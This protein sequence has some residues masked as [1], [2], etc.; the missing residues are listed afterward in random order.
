MSKSPRTEVVTTTGETLTHPV[1]STT[2]LT[3]TH[4]VI[5]TTIFTLLVSVCLLLAIHI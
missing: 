5:S 4:L 3:L 2:V 1:I